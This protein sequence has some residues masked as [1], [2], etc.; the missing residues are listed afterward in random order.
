MAFDSTLIAKEHIPHELRRIPNWVNWRLV[1]REGEDKPTK[2][3][4]NPNVRADDPA[5]MANS[6]DPNTWSDFDRAILRYEKSNVSM[7][8]NRHIMQYNGV[9]FVL[10][11]EHGIIAWDFDRCIDPATGHIEDDV[12]RYIAKLDSYTEISP[13]GTG[14][15]ILVYGVLPPAGR[16]KGNVETYDSKRFVTITGRHVPGTS[17]RIEHRQ[18]SIDEIHKEVFGIIV[19]KETKTLENAIAEPIAEDTDL[20]AAARRAKNG[21][22]FKQLFDEGEL[23]KHPSKS[24]ARLSLCEKLAF[25]AGPDVERIDRLFRQSALYDAKWN[26]ARGKVTYGRLTIDRALEG[27]VDFYV[28]NVFSDDEREEAEASMNTEEEDEVASTPKTAVEKAAPDKVKGTRGG[29]IDAIAFMA[30]NGIT[31]YTDSS[32]PKASREGTFANFDLQV[33]AVLVKEETNQKILLAD[34]ICGTDPDVIEVELDTLELKQ[35]SDLYR[36]RN[37]PATAVIVSPLYWHHYHT[38]LAYQAPAKKLYEKSHYGFHNVDSVKNTTLLLP[39]QPHPKYRWNRSGTGIDTAANNPEDRVDGSLH[40]LWG[41][42]DTIEDI[43]TYLAELRD[44]IVGVASDYYVFTLLSWLCACPLS[45]FIR[46]KYQGFP[47]IMVSGL[48]GCGKSAL[49]DGLLPHFGA[50]KSQAGGKDG[51]TIASIRDYLGSNNLVPLSQDEFRE[52]GWKSDILQGIFRNSWDGHGT[53]KKAMTGETVSSLY[54]APFAMLGQQHITD[55]AAVERTVS[56]RLKR[57]FVDLREKDEDFALESADKLAWLQERRHNGVLMRILVKFIMDNLEIIPD[58]IEGAYKLCKQYI[59]NPMV[60]N[61]Q[62]ISYTA[63]ISGLILLRMVYKT[64]DVPMNDWLKYSVVIPEIFKA[65]PDIAKHKKSDTIDMEMVFSVLSATIMDCHINK[66]R[67]P[68]NKVIIFNGPDQTPSEKGYRLKSKYMYADALLLFEW[69]RSNSRARAM[70]VT[71]SDMVSFISLIED[72]VRQQDSPIISFGD[73]D[74][75]FRKNCIK[76]DL[77]RVIDDYGI[78]A[79]LWNPELNP[80]EEDIENG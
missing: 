36:I 74:G 4:Y 38:W 8:V 28:P 43:R 50:M 41:K 78:N 46:S 35:A 24:E 9:G 58:I 71:L 63:V 29:Q 61:R 64:Y 77:D 20:L 79:E 47:L 32:N 5:F 53:P 26:S 3:P 44:N 31:S 12:M 68:I 33:T 45:E 10:T 27:K 80:D 72:R 60:R 57:D 54:R 62:M 55:G 13:S 25:W 40:A 21:E 51:A 73:E 6:I 42:V 11:K 70:G 17:T 7:P 66:K 15:R 49:M 67:L 69:L 76:I 19:P 2:V 14:M 48:Q 1:K 34:L 30:K 18:D 22:E 52:D 39:G 65:D 59:P 75:P 16:K 37:W 56:I 23:G